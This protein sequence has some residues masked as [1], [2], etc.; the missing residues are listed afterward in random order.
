MTLDQP[1]AEPDY[2]M[3]DDM[4]EWSVEHHEELARHGAAAIHSLPPIQHRQRW[5][6]DEVAPSPEEPDS[7]PG[8]PN[9]RFQTERL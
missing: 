4:A 9:H 7:F 1:R 8:L 5:A 6:R 3:A 2:E